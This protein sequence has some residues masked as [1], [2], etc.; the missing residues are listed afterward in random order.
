MGS[1]PRI[2]FSHACQIFLPQA[3]LLQCLCDHRLGPL[4]SSPDLGSGMELN[5]HQVKAVLAPLR[6]AG[7]DEG[8]RILIAIVVVA[9]IGVVGY[10]FVTEREDGFKIKAQGGDK[11]ETVTISGGSRKADDL[12]EAAEDLKEAGTKAVEAAGD[13]AITAAVKARLAADSELS[14]RNIEVKTEHGVV[15]LNGRVASPSLM[16]KASQ[17]AKSVPG[18]KEVKTNL[19]AEADATR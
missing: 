11:G 3:C 14:A 5:V 17:L 7:N 13:A 4:L 15:T 10:W 1:V 18:V 9:V 8:M 12:K 19:H 16:E 2:A 6:R